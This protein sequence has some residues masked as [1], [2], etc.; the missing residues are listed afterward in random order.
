MLGKD[1]AYGDCKEQRARPADC[2]VHNSLKATHE[3]RRKNRTSRFL[4]GHNRC[5]NMRATRVGR[6]SHLADIFIAV[7]NFWAGTLAD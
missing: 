5:T 4:S 1:T 3:K 2:A 7:F 6:A